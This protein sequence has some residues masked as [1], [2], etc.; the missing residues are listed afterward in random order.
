VIG[1]AIEVHHHLGP[2]LLESIYEA[3][4]CHELSRAGIAFVRPRKLKVRYHGDL[5]CDFVLDLVVE[6]LLVLEIKAVAQLLPIHEAQLLTYLQIS[7]LQLG[8][9]LNLNELRLNTSSAEAARPPFR[10]TRNRNDCPKGTRP[11][12]RRN[13]AALWLCG[14]AYPRIDTSRRM[15]W[16]PPRLSKTPL[17][18]PGKRY[19][20][21]AEGSYTALATV[22]AYG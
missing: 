6:G 17:R 18:A 11:V 4:L 14:K 1:G 22:L 3:A 7:G 12:T 16:N 13:S 10:Q 2:G 8:L 15:S 20:R 5:D 19:H 9:L 21:A